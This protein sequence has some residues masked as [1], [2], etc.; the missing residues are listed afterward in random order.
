MNL[1]RI[2][3]STLPAATA[4]ALDRHAAIARIDGWNVETVYVPR[5]DS[6]NNPRGVVNI[7]ESVIWP[8]LAK[9]PERPHVFVVGDVPMPRSGFN[10]NP[11]GHSDTTGAYPCPGYWASGDQTGWTDTQNNTGFPSKPVFEHTAGDYV[12]DQ[13]HLPAPARCAVG[14]LNLTPSVKNARWGFTGPQSTWVEQAYNRY[15]DA[16][17]CWKCSI[18][19]ASQ[20]FA[21]GHYQAPRADTR[22]LTNTNPEQPVFKTGDEFG[23]SPGPYGF[24]YDFKG[25]P[26]NGDFWFKR[27]KPVA[28]VYLTWESYQTDFNASRLQ[29][30]LLSGSAAVAPVGFEWDMRGALEKTI[31]ELWQQNATQGRTAWIALYGD[32]TF[33]FNNL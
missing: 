9:N 13:N 5:R 25:L 32:P 12:W 33:K 31:G 22:W 10:L 29:N 8:W 28:A 19:R 11:D 21:H 15:F 26:S 16:L 27:E 14:I 1:L 7:A 24:M 30:A 17:A 20:I 2:I 4:P 3:E 6:K 18:T 23:R